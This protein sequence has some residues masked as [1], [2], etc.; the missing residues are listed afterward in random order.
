MDPAPRTHR[1]P[2]GP[3]T[4]HGTSL[5]EK[6]SDDRDNGPPAAIS[7]VEPDEAAD[8]TAAQAGDDD[9]FA[10]IYDRL[11]PVVLSLCRQR[12][13]SEAEDAAQETF[14]RAHRLLHKVEKAGR[15]R[16]WI[17]AIARRVCS[18][19]TRAAR[20]R[21]R[22]EERAA[23]S[24]QEVRT[25]SGRGAPTT[26]TATGDPSENSDH[27]EQLERLGT[28][29]EKLDDRERLAIHLYYLE[30]DPMKAATGAMSLSRSGYYKLLAR[31][32]EH[33][34]GFMTEMNAP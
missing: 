11:G 33:L 1:P 20:R 9:A 28:A 17:Y 18:E 32:R 24:R 12:S 23:V 29:L 4:T 10:R 31:A 27:A 34:A 14:I 26:G 22:H 25:P 7:T 3:G 2:A 21:A 5:G 13:L 8:L 19:R 30:A 6:L 16:P 15:L